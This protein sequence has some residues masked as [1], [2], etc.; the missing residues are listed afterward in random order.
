[1]KWRIDD[2]PIFAAIVEQNGLSAAARTLG[3]S[4][5]TVSSALA[6]LEQA[7]G[8]RLFVRNSRNIRLTPEGQTFYRQALLIL[9]QVR[10]A[11]ATAAGLSSEPAG[12]LAVALPPAFAQEV[13]APRLAQFADRYPEVE[14]EIIVTAQG[15]DPLRDR[16][17]VAVVVGPLQDSDLISRTLLSGHLAWVTSPAYLEKNNIDPTPEGL[18]KHVQL[19]ETRY[20]LAKMPV[21][22]AGTATYIDLLT[23]ITHVNDPLVVRQAVIGGAGLSPLPE[24]YCRKPVSDGTLVAVGSEVTFDLSASILSVVYPHRM[25]MSPRLRAFVDFLSDVSK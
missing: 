1:M 7:L 12:Q 15:I 3:L 9:E 18:R 4:K 14:L 20:G 23:G 6:R 19:C 8:F 24:L 11:D 21:H 10:E 16:I 22:A 2:V 17:D 13:V 5:S 25:L